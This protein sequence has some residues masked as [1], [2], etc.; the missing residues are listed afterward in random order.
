[1]NKERNVRLDILRG[2]A[3]ILMVMGHSFFSGMHF[4]YLF[5][6]ALFFMMGGYFFDGKNSDSIRN[7][8]RFILKRIKGLWLPFVIWN[9]IFL[10]FNNVFVRIGVYSDNPMFLEKFSG[11]YASL[12]HELD[13]MQTLKQC[14]KGL[15]FQSGTELGGAFWFFRI[16]LMISVS[17]VIIDFILKKIP[18]TKNISEWIQLGVST[19]FLILGYV[20]YLRGITTLGLDRML[21]Y[22]G[23][24][25]LG[26]HIVLVEKYLKTN[27]RKISVFAVAVGILIICNA[28]G[29]VALD[30]NKY[31]NP[32]FLIVAS[33]SGWLMIYIAS[34]YIYMCKTKHVQKTDKIQKTKHIQTVKVTVFARV[35]SYIGQNTL[36][37][38]VLHL[39]CFKLVNYLIVAV[40]RMPDYMTAAYPVV[41]KDGLWWILY[42]IVG[43]GIPVGITYS[44]QKLKMYKK[45]EMRQR[46]V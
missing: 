6:M 5:H 15:F 21:S 32:I 4:V 11:S 7:V 37:V 22:Y 16:Y 29:T 17:Y 35:L 26:K 14:V 9:T 12:H 45:C 34:D 13:M 24:F 30:S 39:L 42:T 46:K 33:V 19:I 38:F 8:G 18:I 2:I 31:V 36:S 27:I 44:W 41:V 1:M 3:I 23:L 28:T 43:V 40:Y 20:C 25:F 10:L